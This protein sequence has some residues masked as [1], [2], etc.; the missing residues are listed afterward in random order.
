M[1]LN[2]TTT[3]LLIAMALGCEPKEEII[4]GSDSAEPTYEYD[5]ADRDGIIDGH[6]GYD[7]AAEL[8]IYVCGGSLAYAIIAT[9]DDG[10]YNIIIRGPK[11][12]V[13]YR[14]N[15]IT[16]PFDKSCYDSHQEKITSC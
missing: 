4:A 5:D 9:H 6:D 8:L 16:C 12:M 7:D 1:R 2:L 10:P 3:P 13:T 14:F 11:K 15:T